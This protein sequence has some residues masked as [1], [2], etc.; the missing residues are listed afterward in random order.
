MQCDSDYA[1][2]QVTYSVP[3]PDSNKA[4]IYYNSVLK[5]LDFMM[6]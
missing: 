5:N 3:F 1:L 6:V 4:H 2:A